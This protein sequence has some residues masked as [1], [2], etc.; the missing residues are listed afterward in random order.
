[1]GAA[2][3]RGKIHWRPLPGASGVCVMAR[4]HHLPGMPVGA[5]PLLARWVQQGT[6]SY[7]HATAVQDALRDNGASLTHDVCPAHTQFTLRAADWLWAARF[8]VELLHTPTLDT[9]TWEDQNLV[10]QEEW[11]RKPLPD[12]LSQQ[13]GWCAPQRIKN[14]AELRGVWRQVYA[15][16]Q[17]ELWVGGNI[18]PSSTGLL[19]ALSCAEPRTA[20]T[21][22]EWAATP[23]PPLM[24]AAPVHRLPCTG[25]SLL[26]LVYAFPPLVSVGTQAVLA[27]LLEQHLQHK[28]RDCRSWARQAQ[29]EW[30]AHPGAVCLCVTLHASRAEMQRGT[31]SYTDAV[32]SWAPTLAEV[33][34]AQRA[35][36]KRIAVQQDSLAACTKQIVPDTRDSD[37]MH[38]M[39]RVLCGTYLCDVAPL[40]CVHRC[41]AQKIV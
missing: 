18:P 7:S 34:A 10:W 5:A 22:I 1:M 25:S 40:A 27:F 15:A 29:C 36:Q 21:E 33:A 26:V 24:V 20:P 28:C 32:S 12:W 3:S 16:A 17:M 41:S 6:S 9:D 2:A 38:P 8:M 35:L 30:Y 13:L 31:S 11:R 14:A 37:K 23:F 19:R 39:L 4:V